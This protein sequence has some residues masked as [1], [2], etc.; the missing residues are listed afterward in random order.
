MDTLNFKTQ[1]AM[2]NKIK[3]EKSFIETTEDLVL[4]LL[5]KHYS[6]SKC[7][8]DAFTKAKIKGLLNRAISQEIEY[9]K[10][11]PDVYFGVYGDH[12]LKN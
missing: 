5:K 1:Q 12:H 10:E 6:S 11:H 4:S 3:I 9:L 7:Q 8:I 2:E